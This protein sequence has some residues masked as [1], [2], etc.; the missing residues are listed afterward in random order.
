MSN[1]Y[2]GHGAAPV[3]AMR[4]ASV[5]LGV[6]S[7]SM[8]SNVRMDILHEARVALGAD[9]SERDVWELATLDGARALRMDHA[10]GSLEAGKQADLAAFAFDA[11]HD[12]PA[13][14]VFVAVAGR[15]L[16][17]DRQV[18]GY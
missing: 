16:V 10:I 17:N 11:E 4:A 2:F 7:D 3:G 18:Q 5:R 1:R 8:A 9:A 13:R 14:A 12:A 6:G 15:V